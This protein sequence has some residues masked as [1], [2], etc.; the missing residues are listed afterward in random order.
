VS[1]VE[2]LGEDVPIKRA[3]KPGQPE[4]AQG[5]EEVSKLPRQQ[6]EKIV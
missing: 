3:R 4:S 2:L 6:Q 1:V 5:F